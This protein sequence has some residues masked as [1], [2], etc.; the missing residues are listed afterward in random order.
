[1]FTQN[2]RAPPSRP[3][4]RLD[5]D[6]ARHAAQGGDVAHRLV[7]VPGTGGQEAGQRGDVDDLRP[8]GGVVVDLLVRA[9]GQE[10]RERVHHRQEAAK[11]HAARLGDHVLLRDPAL[12][13]AVGKPLAKRD[14]A[15]VEDQV[16]VQHH[17]PRVAFGLAHER[18]RVGGHEALRCPGI[19]VSGRGSRS[20]RSSPP[21]SSRSRGWPRRSAPRRPWRTL[22]RS[23]RRCGT[24]TAIRGVHARRLHERHALALDRVGDQH[25]WAVGDRP[26]PTERRGHRAEVVPVARSTCQPKA[27]NFASRSPK[28]LTSATQVSDWIL[29][30]ST[31][32]LISP[33]PSAAADGSDSQNW[34]S[35]SSPSPVRTKTRAG[36]PGGGWPAPS[37]WPWRCP[38]RASRCWP[39][40]RAS[41]RRDGPAGHRAAAVRGSARSRAARAR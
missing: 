18:P 23:A 36:A 38:C 5:H 21:P 10:A 34:P 1:M 14:Q 12:E 27:P 35:W 29:L 26:Q 39:R 3:R 8:L 25:L 15:A 6:Q 20:S 30:W 9:R 33:S 32:T 11:R 40:R 2:S 41:P 7:G 19:A 17:Q 16:G 24:G 37:P 13:E 31:M 4:S 28:S 22:R